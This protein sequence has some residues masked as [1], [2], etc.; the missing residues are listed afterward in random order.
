MRVVAHPSELVAAPLK[1]PEIAPREIA[2]YRV[3]DMPQFPADAFDEPEQGWVVLIV[4]VG[5]DGMPE[6]MSIA[7]S[8]SPAIDAAAVA[9]VTKWR[10]EPGLIAGKAVK[11]WLQVPIGFFKGSL[12]KGTTYALSR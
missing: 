7:R 6:G 10:F 11:S 2:S 8:V 1:R 4:L 9:A 12:S 5:E 3:T